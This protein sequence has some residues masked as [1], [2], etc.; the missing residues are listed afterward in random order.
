MHE[1]FDHGWVESGVD[2]R[3]KYRRCDVEAGAH[4]SLSQTVNVLRDVMRETTTIGFG[5]MERG[6][7]Y[8]AEMEE[9]SGDEGGDE[10][11]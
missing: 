3:P 7:R 5:G 10:R 1:G 6:V 8:H 9:E 4:L 11:C 2:L